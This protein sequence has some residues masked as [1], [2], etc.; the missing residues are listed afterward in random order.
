MWHTI[1]GLAVE[2]FIAPVGSMHHMKKAASLKVAVG[3]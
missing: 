3:A 1:T 2:A